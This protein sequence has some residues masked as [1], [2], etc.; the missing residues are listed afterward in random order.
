MEEAA[1]A[2]HVAIIDHGSIAV[3]GTPAKLKENYSNDSLIITPKDT[4]GIDDILAAKGYKY[5][6]KADT[7]EITVR[8]SMYALSVLKD[9]EPHIS[10]FEVIKGNM[11]NVFMNITG[12][13]IRGE[14]D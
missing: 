4:G 6:K 3:Q 11:D 10:S 12:H 5:S 9:I 8:D 2:D 7:V 14:D 13:R 1:S